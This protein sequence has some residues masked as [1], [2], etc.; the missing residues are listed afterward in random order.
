M[1]NVLGWMY[2]DKIIA[3]MVKTLSSNIKDSQHALE[4]FR[5]FNFPG[6]KNLFSLRI[7]LY[8]RLVFLPTLLSCSSRFLRALQQNRAQSR[9]LYLLTIVPYP[10]LLYYI[11]SYSILL[12]DIVLQIY[13]FISVSLESL[14][15]FFKAICQSS[16]LN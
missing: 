4:I 9:L 16:T 5:G 14:N 15:S 3:P 7:L 13:L 2:L 6:K 12:Y 1:L 11:L 10:K 8:L